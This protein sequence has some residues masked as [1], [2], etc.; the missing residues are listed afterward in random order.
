MSEH[1]LRNEHLQVI[2]DPTTLQAEVLQLASGLRW[3]FGRHAEAELQVIYGTTTIT[4]RLSDARSITLRRYSTLTEERLGYM[5]EGL[6]GNVGLL[7][8]FILPANQ[9]FLRIELD[10]LPSA[11]AATIGEVWYPGPLTSVEDE[12]QY[13]VWPNM[14]GTLIPAHHPQSIGLPPDAETAPVGW[15]ARNEALSRTLYQP[16][17]GVVGRRGAYLAIAETPFDFSLDIQ[18]PSGGPTRTSPTWLPSLG[19]LAY[20]RA[21]RYQFFAG[22]DYVTLAKA[23][24]DYSRSIG[25]WMSLQDKFERNPIAER[26]VGSV[27]FPVSVCSYNQQQKPPAVHVTSFS[28]LTSRVRRMRALGIERAYY[29]VDGWGFHGYDNHHPDVLPPCPEAGGW[30]G[31]IELSRAA[32]KAGHLLG[33]HD[34]YRDYYLDGPAFQESR[35]VKQAD[36]SLPY[37]DYWAGGPQSVLCAKEALPYVRRTFTEL[38]GRGVKLSASYLDVFAV[39]NMDECYDI[40]HPMTREDCYR[41]RTEA[42][43]YVRSLGLAIS[44][45]EP[46]DHFVPHLDFAHWADSPRVDFMRGDHLGVP[47]PLH[48]LVYHDALLLPAAFDYAYDPALRLTYFLQGLAQVEIPYGKIAW[49]DQESFAQ[50]NLMAQLHRAWGTQELVG[51]KLLEADGSVQEYVYPEGKISIDLHEGR[52]RIEGGPLATEGWCGATVQ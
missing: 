14:A 36:G 30:D 38:L 21:I 46:V 47:V 11:S 16:W 52:Y 39:V 22:V 25:R 19:R 10:P 35:T 32:D 9:A 28:H 49:D 1:V 31:L 17:W 37:I 44:S 3:T 7:V 23:Y 4:A 29:H 6:P 51:H 20:P 42:L 13:T 12:P 27:I 50:V 33:L 5:L 24:R 43:D 41:W 18:H 48:N 26:L 2:V 15:H 8:T 45:E 34:Q 40:G